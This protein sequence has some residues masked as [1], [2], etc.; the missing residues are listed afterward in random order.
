VK[1][2]VFDHISG[3]E[4]LEATVLP[5]IAKLGLLGARHHDGFFHP[6]DTL[7]DQ[8]YLDELVATKSAP[9]MIW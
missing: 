9:W 7:R 6:M 3:N 2:E 5:R 4:S 1:P 8:S